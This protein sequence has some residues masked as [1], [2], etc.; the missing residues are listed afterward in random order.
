[1]SVTASTSGPNATTATWTTFSPSKTT[2]VVEKLK[3]K[4]LGTADTP[5]VKRPTDNL[6]AYNLVLQGPVLFPEGDRP[7]V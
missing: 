6:E 4:L 7:G 5:L 3:V 1:M 2:A